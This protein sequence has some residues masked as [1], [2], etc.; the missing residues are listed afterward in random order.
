MPYVAKLIGACVIAIAAA[1]HAQ[2]GEHLSSE[3]VKIALSAK[4]GSG[5]VQVEDGAFNTS[6]L[7]QAQMPSELI[8]TPLGWLNALSSSA[9]KK[10]LPFRP[11][12]EDTA[13]MLTVVTRGCANQT[14]AGPDCHPIERVALLSDMHGSIRVEPKVQESTPPLWPNGERSPITCFGVVSRFSIAEVQ[15]L[16]KPRRQLFVATFLDS[17]LL[18]LYALR[19]EDLAKLGI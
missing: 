2:S 5:F 15:K 19:E 17:Q 16:V 11:R 6:A 12:P 4:P 9:R 10:S 1:G 7:C 3:E 13:R 18:K 8:F 14:D